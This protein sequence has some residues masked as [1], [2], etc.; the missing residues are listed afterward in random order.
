MKKFIKTLIKP[1]KLYFEIGAL[2][3]EKKEPIILLGL[4]AIT[5]AILVELPI[6]IALITL[7]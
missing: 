6:I 3:I 5:F 7:M 1:V 2:A 4:F